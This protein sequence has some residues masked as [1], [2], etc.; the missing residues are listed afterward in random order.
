[1]VFIE[2]PPS[3]SRTERHTYKRSEYPIGLADIPIQKTYTVAMP[4]PLPLSL[5]LR[6]FKRREC[7]C[8]AHSKSSYSSRSCMK[9][10]T[11]SK[12]SFSAS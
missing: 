6:Q 2:E 8:V 9:L 11:A 5:P 10:L 1:M 3:Q 7:R 12:A 4:D